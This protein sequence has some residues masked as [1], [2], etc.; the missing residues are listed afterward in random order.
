MKIAKTLSVLTLAVAASG[1]A[2]VIRGT[3]QDFHIETDPPGATATLSTGQ[4]CT[5]PCTLRLPRKEA[6]DVTFSM[7]GY[8]EGTAHVTSGWSR[9]GTQTFVVGNIILG[10]LVGMGVDASNGATRDLNPNPLVATLIEEGAEMPATT[11][12]APASPSAP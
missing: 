11:P 8:Q 6:F 3:K 1:C 5:T 7:D 4:T 10:G 2:T 12:A 9:A